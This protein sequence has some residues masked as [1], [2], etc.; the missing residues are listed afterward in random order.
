MKGS[1]LLDIGKSMFFVSAFCLAFSSCHKATPAGFW[2]DF[3]K[4]LIV[5]SVEKKIIPG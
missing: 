1:G 3:R 2:L 4:D 5:K